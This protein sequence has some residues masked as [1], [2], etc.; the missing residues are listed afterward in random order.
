ML[1]GGKIMT[2][3][4]LLI[5]GALV[6]ERPLPP[7]IGGYT[8]NSQILSWCKS[9]DEREFGLCWSFIAGVAEASGMPTSKWPKGPIELPPGVLAHHLIPEVI[10]HIES[11]PAEQM[12]SPA[13]VS[14]YE[15]AVALYPYRS[16]TVGLETAED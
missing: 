9:K 11:L 7:H 14:I 4:G 6:T 8:P 15:A 10:E 1:I 5:S 3:I 16:Q 2:I 12:S 13:A